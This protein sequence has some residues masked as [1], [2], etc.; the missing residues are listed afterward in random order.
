M[1][2]RNIAPRYTAVVIMS[3]NKITY[4]LLRTDFYEIFR[5]NYKIVQYEETRFEKKKKLSRFLRQTTLRNHHRKGALMPVALV[6]CKSDV[7]LE[8]MYFSHC[9]NIHNI[10]YSKVAKCQFHI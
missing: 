3:H 7:Y 2:P 1:D 8:L 9:I 10:S 5:L 6:K 4:V